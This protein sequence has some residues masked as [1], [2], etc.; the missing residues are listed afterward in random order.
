MAFAAFAGMRPSEIQGISGERDGLDWSDIDFRRH[1]I[2]V[3]PE[4][5]GKLSE[6]RYIS[7]TAKPTVGLSDEIADM[8]WSAL[9]SHLE[10]Y[11]KNS[12]PVTPRK[13]QS[14]LSDELRQAGLI[15]SWPKDALRHTWISSMLA[16]GVHRD[17]V[18]ELAG[19]SS[20]IIR[21]NYK[22]PLPEDDAR[23]WFRIGVGQDA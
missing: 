18:A 13:C 10:P 22:R 12:G 5:A 7:L 8:I 23:S 19:N 16:L 17:W 21:T 1:H 3:R 11:R 9:S 2:R 14:Y 20:A 6:P 15:K 4:V